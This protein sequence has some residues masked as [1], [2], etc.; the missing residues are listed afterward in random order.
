MIY[1]IRDTDTQRGIGKPNRELKRVEVPAG[2]FVEQWGGYYVFEPKGYDPNQ[3]RD[4]AGRWASGAGGGA[5]DPATDPRAPANPEGKDTLERYKKADGTWTPARQKLHEEIIARAFEG[6]EPVPNP[7]A[8]MMG[9]GPASGKSSAIKAG[10]IVIP[11][12]T[13]HIDSDAIK[14]QLPDFQDMVAAKDAKAAAFSHEESSYLAGRILEEASRGGYNSMLDGTG[15]SSV[16]SVMKKTGTMR[17]G[18]SR[19]VANYVTCDTEQAV[20]RSR[21]RGAK[22]GRVVPEDF[23]RACHAAVSRTVPEAIAAGAYDEFALYD[24]S[25]EGQTIKVAEAQGSNLKVHDQ[26]AWAKFLAKGV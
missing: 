16:G 21:A 26:A 18:G 11:D 17:K 23:I 4:E 24:T 2:T 12:N 13:V 1:D 10:G 22:T 15:D 5:G 7:V 14:A 8:Y 20:E 25:T 3:P 19:V 9:G 6:K